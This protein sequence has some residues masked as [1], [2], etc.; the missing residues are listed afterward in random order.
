M[1]EDSKPVIK[2]KRKRVKKPKKVLKDKSQKVSQIVSIKIGSD[3]IKPKPRRRQPSRAK[4]KPPT[5]ATQPKQPVKTDFGF[6]SSSLGGGLGY[7]SPFRQVLYPTSQ[8][9]SNIQNI[10]T[11]LKT[12]EKS[13]SDI[14]STRG[15]VTGG[16]QTAGTTRGS[17]TGDDTEPRQIKTPTIKKRAA[18]G[19]GGVVGSELSPEEIAE[20]AKKVGDFLS[21]QTPTQANRAMANKV[22]QTGETVRFVPQPRKQTLDEEA[23]I[24]AK[25]AEQIAA[26]E[27]A[28]AASRRADAPIS[29]ETP[30]KRKPGRPKKEQGP[31]EGFY[32]IG[33]FFPEALPL[34]NVQQGQGADAAATAD[35]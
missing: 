5:D 24:R 11:G 31:P 10:A 3:I 32:S 17:Q 18:A 4:P 9:E 20:S 2:V 25:Q 13:V 26:S 28:A 14:A 15:S 27:R 22:L 30:E 19:G 7:D 1:A 8:Q 33:A 16:S 23:A 21:G 29:G 6:R 35:L 12:L 34:G